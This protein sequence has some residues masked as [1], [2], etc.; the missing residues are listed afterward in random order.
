MKFQIEK[1]KDIFNEMLPLF[2][3]HWEEIAH[4]K[5]IKLEIDKESYFKMEEIGL[6]RIFTAR[7][8]DNSLAGYAVFI[9]KHNLHYKSSLQALQDVL[10]IDKEK[11]GFG[12]KFILWCDKQLK[13]EGVQVVY[14]HIKAAHN[15]GKMIERLGY[16]LQDLIYCRR[17]DLNV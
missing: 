12:A 6:L 15:W 3:K 14:H 9:I 2:E 4:F 16:Q 10:Y 8:E 5:D 17:L 1:L 13:Q 11:R 7:E